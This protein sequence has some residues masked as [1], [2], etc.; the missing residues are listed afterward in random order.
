[1][2]WVWQRWEDWEIRP[3]NMSSKLRST[4]WWNWLSILS[5]GTRRCVRGCGLCSGVYAWLH[6]IP[7]CRDIIIITAKLF[8]ELRIS[9]V[10]SSPLQ[11]AVTASLV[12]VRT[13]YPPQFL[14]FPSSSPSSDFPKRAH[15]E[16]IRC[17]RQ[18]TIPLSHWQDSHGDKWWALHQDQGW[19]WEQR[20]PHHR[21]WVR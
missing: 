20:P 1:M 18:D 11:L 21:H 17:S 2:D 14:N 5:T 15:I 10:H 12:T 7:A 9:F 13:S 16:C 4:G 6:Y 8:V 19:P 3:R